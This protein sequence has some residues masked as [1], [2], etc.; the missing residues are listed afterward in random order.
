M[1]WCIRCVHL[2]A[3][4]IFPVIISIIPEI[5][6][7]WPVNKN[8]KDADH[9]FLHAIDPWPDSSDVISYPISPYCKYT[10]VNI[11]MQ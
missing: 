6:L 8:M 4:Q 2:F 9:F 10:L 3:L 5:I 1:Q 11:S 7:D